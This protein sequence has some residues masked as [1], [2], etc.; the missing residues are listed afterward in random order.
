MIKKLAV[1]LAFLSFAVLVFTPVMAQEKAEAKKAGA[2]KHEYVGAT[3]CKICHTKD[4]VYPTWEKTKHAAAYSVIPED[5]KKNT[6]C[7]GCHTTG[8]T[9][10]GVL[11][12]NVQCEACHGPGGDY[13]TMSI[14]KDKEKAIANGLIIP[15]S[16]TCVRCHL[17]KPPAFEGH[18]KLAEFNYKEMKA[19]G[20]HAMPPA[21]ATKEKE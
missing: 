7:Q 6:E 12:E 2:P 1:I 9:A 17:G 16:T 18:P 13:K 10:K 14:M 19:K 8:V 21:E 11:L 15:D 20:L 5:Q 3:M 4:N